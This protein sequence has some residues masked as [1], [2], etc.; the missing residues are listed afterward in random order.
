MWKKSS[1]QP[2]QSGKKIKKKKNQNW[3]S[4]TWIDWDVN[5][6]KTLIH[7]WVPRSLAQHGCFPPTEAQ[8]HEQYGWGRCPLVAKKGEQAIC[9]GLQKE[10]QKGS[11]VLSVGG[12]L[13]VLARLCLI[14]A[15]EFH[16]SEHGVWTVVDKADQHACTSICS[17]INICVY[18]YI[19]IYMYIHR[20][21]H[22][23]SW[24]KEQVRLFC[25]F[26]G[27]PSRLL[28]NVHLLERETAFV[29]A[30]EGYL[31]AEEQQTGR[32]SCIQ[33]R[34]CCGGYGGPEL[35]RIVCFRTA[36]RE[37][38]RAEDRSGGC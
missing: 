32:C 27:S 22:V 20:Y 26:V 35:N 31:E 28:L 2:S 36:A 37:V 5:R 19:C 23:I 3:E 4:T 25:V 29:R 33:L 1:D 18:I 34:E 21:V 24:G 11:K 12:S 30:F 6:E 14:P 13:G 9:V 10:R 8:R 7:A 38:A 16:Q 15:E 17:A